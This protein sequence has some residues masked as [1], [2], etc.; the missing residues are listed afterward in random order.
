MERS[1]HTSEGALYESVA[2]GNKDTYFFK[3]DVNSA[4]N[5]FEQRYDHV[6]PVIHELRRIPPY[7]GADFGRSSEFEFEVAGDVFTNPTILVDLPSWL[8]SDYV[9]AARTVTDASGNTYGYSAGVGYFLFKK[10]PAVP[11]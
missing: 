9:A 6:P 3:D 1:G 11:G 10:D 7:N 4:L 5:P 2:R 8:P